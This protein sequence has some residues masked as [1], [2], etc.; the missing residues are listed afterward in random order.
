MNDYFN[1]KTNNP[2][3]STYIIPWLRQEIFSMN[4][5]LENLFG[6][7]RTINEL[8]SIL[9]FLSELFSK[10][11]KKKEQNEE[12]RKKQDKIMNTLQNLIKLGEECK[13]N[14]L[15]NSPLKIR[16]DSKN[17]MKKRKV[18]NEYY[19]G[20]E[21]SKNNTSTF[22]DKQE[23]Y[24]SIIE[25]K[26]VLNYSKIEKT[27][28]NADD[29]TTNKITNN[30]NNNENNLRK[31]SSEDYDGNYSKNNYNNFNNNKGF[32]NKLTELRAKV[33][34]TIKR[35]SE[36]FNKENIKYLEDLSNNFE[37]SIMYF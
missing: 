7:V 34:N 15:N 27:E 23:Y 1:I 24:K 33:I 22:I 28:T 3:Y 8:S 37:Q 16:N 29:M 19:I 4:K 31:L 18:V 36:L 17:H 20:T 35:S 25:S 10:M 2:V 13:Y 30:N 12:M 32:D 9:D 5:Q 21:E 6:K 26:N 14:N 11:E